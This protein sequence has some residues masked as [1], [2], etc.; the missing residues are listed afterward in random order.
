MSSSLL[1][2]LL[3]K[4]TQLTP[5]VTVVRPHPCICAGTKAFGMSALGG[6]IEAERE[7]AEEDTIAA[8]RAVAKK[9]RAS[10]S[11]VVYTG[12]GISTATGISDYRGPKGVWTS[13]ARGVIP[14]EA[15]DITS[16]RPSFTHMALK[17]LVDEGLV[18]F[19]VSTNLDGLHYKS[20]MTPLDNLAEMHGSM[21]YERCARCHKDSPARPFPVR[22]GGDPNKSHP[23]ATGRW[24]SCGGMY[25]DS[26]IDFGQTLPWRHL[27]A[28]EAA[29][30]QSDF[31][32]VVGTSMRVAPAST[33]PF[34]LGGAKSKHGNDNANKTSAVASSS[35][36]ASATKENVTIVNL[37]D[38]PFDDRAALR[39]FAK[40]DTFFFHLMQELEL[41]CPTPPEVLHLHTATQM[42]ALAKRF[43]P[44]HGRNYVGKA[45]REQEMASALFAVEEEMLAR[46]S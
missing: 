30:E 20:G 10:R 6:R 21:W 4:R 43:L 32:L 46:E 35:D 7:E 23:R 25:M 15:F 8:A 13:L 22:R 19:I 24:C 3:A 29:A 31:S 40:A 37:M 17:K 27:A 11:A 42:K 1:D 34:V 38:T 28:A 18:K 33:L 41:R 9:L 14:D 16:A 12:A 44:D 45:Q 2:Q 26:G 36:H 5:T 39:S